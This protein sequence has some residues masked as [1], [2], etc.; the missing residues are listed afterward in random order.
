MHDIGHPAEGRPATGAPDCRI[1]N[2]LNALVGMFSLRGT[3]R[4]PLLVLMALT[5]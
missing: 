1:F 3:T 5:S 4:E 2:D